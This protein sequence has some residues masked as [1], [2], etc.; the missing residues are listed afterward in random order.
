MKISS[1]CSIVFILAIFH[2][3]LLGQ[4]QDFFGELLAPPAPPSWSAR[5]SGEAAHPLQQEKFSL[6][7]PINYVPTDPA[8]LTWRGSHLKLETNERL[9][10]GGRIPDD[11]YSSEFGLN[12]KH[13]ESEQK[14]WGFTASIGSAGDKTFNSRTKTVVGANAFYSNSIDP[15]SRWLWFLNYSN[16]RSFLNEI[17]I[18]GVAYVYRPSADFMGVFGFPF[19]FMRVKWNESLSSSFLLGPYIY[20]ADL[21]Q[22]I[23]GPVTAYLSADNSV[24]SFYREARSRDE[25]RLFYSESK[26]LLGIKAPVSSALFV[27]VYGGL[28]YSRFV[29]EAEEYKDA[30]DEENSVTLENRWVAGAQLSLRF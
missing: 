25:D 14:F 17:P 10:N 15:T 19:I 20:R 7:A 8:S 1:L 28:S 27:D 13:H 5:I 3:P 18:P 29:A 4:A 16:N 9:E 26:A 2:F 23:F 24:Q 11:F 22:R 12:Y 6:S 21:S 30:L